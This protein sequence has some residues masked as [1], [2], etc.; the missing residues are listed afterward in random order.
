M[1]RGI[2]QSAERPGYRD[3]RQETAPFLI[4]IDPDGVFRSASRVRKS[5]LQFPKF[6]AQPCQGRQRAENE[7]KQRLI[8]SR[9]DL[10]IGH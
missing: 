10:L 6:A 8:K 4:F 1:L 9:W 2:T 7:I 3:L 5:L